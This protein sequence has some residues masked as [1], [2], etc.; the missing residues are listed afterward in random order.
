MVH[1][2]ILKGWG[3][4]GKE[5]GREEGVRIYSFKNE[6]GR[7]RGGRKGGRGLTC[8]SVSASHTLIVSGPTFPPSSIIDTSS[9]SYK[10]PL[11]GQTTTAVPAPKASR[12]WGR[13]GKVG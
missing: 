11:I 4:G 2:A 10:M 12:S 6:T 13:E 5:G 8:M 9:P 1:L 7:I 3:E